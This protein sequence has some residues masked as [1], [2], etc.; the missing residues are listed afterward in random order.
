M[1]MTE[2]NSWLVG[3]LMPGPLSFFCFAESS[4]SSERRFHLVLVQ[5]HSI[6]SPA[7]RWEQKRHMLELYF[8]D[9]TFPGSGEQKCGLVPTKVFLSKGEK[10]QLVFWTDQDYRFNPIYRIYSID[11]IFDVTSSFFSPA[12]QSRLS[13]RARTRLQRIQLCQLLI[14][15]RRRRLTPSCR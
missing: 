15:Q 9:D 8:Y 13:N 1:G 14:L 5:D 10:R 7:T 11:L 4:L 12:W 3:P 6:F 2:S